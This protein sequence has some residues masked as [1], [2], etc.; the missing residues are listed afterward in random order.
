[1]AFYGWPISQCQSLD[2]PLSVQFSQGIRLLDIRLSVI[3]G[4]LIAYHG[5]YPQRTPFQSILAAMYAFLSE[6]ATCGETLVVSIK[7][8]DFGGNF[9]SRVRKEIEAGP[10]GMG[11][12]FLENR[13]P[14]LG[15]ARGRAIMFSRFGGD[16]SDWEGGLEGLGI[17]PSTWPDS[18]KDGFQWWCKDTLVRT[19]DW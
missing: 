11:M 6:P 14:S 7:Q 5:A 10:G 18:A 1:M 16:G 17:H 3:K 9:S 2:T 8:E 12:W 19:Q 13:I 15:E 4:K